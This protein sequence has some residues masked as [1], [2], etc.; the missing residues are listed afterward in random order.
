MIDSKK[1]KKDVTSDKELSV[2]TDYLQGLRS[3]RKNGGALTVT[4]AM[5][6]T[7]EK[8]GSENR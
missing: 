1:S 8:D 7:L 5:I 4:E 2:L 3:L 6:V